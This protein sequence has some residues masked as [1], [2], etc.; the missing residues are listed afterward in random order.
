MLGKTA[1]KLGHKWS[2]ALE[3]LAEAVILRR[4][5]DSSRTQVHD[6]LITTMMAV[7]ELLDTSTGGNGEHLVAKANAKDRKLSDKPVGKFVCRR[8]RLRISRSIG[9]KDAIGIKGENI[10]KCRVPGHDRHIA[11]MRA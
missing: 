3:N 1:R 5:L 10:V 8:N 4:D 2:D 7:F 9:E 11:S 6:G